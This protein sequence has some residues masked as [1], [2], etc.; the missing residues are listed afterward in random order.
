VKQHERRASTR[1]KLLAAAYRLSGSNSTRAA[2]RS[3]G[4]TD[5]DARK[6]AALALPTAEASTT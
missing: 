3:L 1:H 6:L 2:L 5:R 4:V